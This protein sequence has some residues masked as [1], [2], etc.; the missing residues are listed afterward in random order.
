MYLQKV[1]NDSPALSQMQSKQLI[2]MS[3]DTW[4][5]DFLVSVMHVLK[6]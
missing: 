5:L 1:N 4:H 3:S 6:M 2:C